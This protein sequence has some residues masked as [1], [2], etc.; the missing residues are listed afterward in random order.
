MYP[1]CIQTNHHTP[2]TPAA[3]SFARFSAA[4]FSLALRILLAATIFISLLLLQ[5]DR[6]QEQLAAPLDRD[7][8]T[9]AAGTTDLQGADLRPPAA[10]RTAANGRR[11]GNGDP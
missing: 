9:G 8:V 11:L 4:S 3:L 5:L 6:L 2:N 10:G 7:V 1:R